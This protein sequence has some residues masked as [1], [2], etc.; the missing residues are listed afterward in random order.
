[1]EWNEKVQNIIK[2]KKWSK[3][4][5]RLGRV[6][7]GKL[8]EEKGE[9]GLVITSDV[10]TKPLYGRV[11]KMV[12]ADNEIIVFYDDNYASILGEEEY[13]KFSNYFSKEEWQSL[14]GGDTI[15]YLEKM[16]LIEER[17]GFYLETHE[18]VEQYLGKSDENATK[19]LCS[20]FNL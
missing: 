15:E 17:E 5:I 9:L 3:N 20:K 10:L 16:N 2:D 13:D 18:T 11:E 1:M 12:V 14:F 8:M 4:S 6:Q 7:C 19:D